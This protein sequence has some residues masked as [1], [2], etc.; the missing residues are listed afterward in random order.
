VRTTLDLSWRARLQATEPGWL[1]MA[2]GVP[3][4][5]TSRARNELGWTAKVSAIDALAELLS[6]IP[7]RSTGE[8]PVL[9]A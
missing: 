8:T 7:V 4:M 1:D 2:L 9:A 6:G 5:D 3:V